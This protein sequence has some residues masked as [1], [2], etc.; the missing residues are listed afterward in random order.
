MPNY[1]Q[2]TQEMIGNIAEGMF[3]ETATSSAN[4]Y[5]KATQTELFTV[6]G[7]I[8]VK[9][10]YI[11]VIADLSAQATQVQFNC[12]F[13]T[14]TIGVNAMGAACAS[15]SGKGQGTR[16][17]HVGGAVSVAAVI[18]DSAGLSDVTCITP[19][20]VGG[21]AFVGSIGMLGSAATIAT[22][23]FRAMLHYVPYSTGAYAEAAL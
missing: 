16:I 1:N 2:S 5:L 4:T 9:Q 14:P 15:I 17:V 6:V 13:T 20:I 12:T 3:V 10:L 7:R 22:G 21:E 23:T 19:H 11:E 18:T 8:L